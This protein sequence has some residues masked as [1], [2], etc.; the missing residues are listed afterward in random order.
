[1]PLLPVSSG[2][3]PRP[4]PEQGSVPE[5]SHPAIPARPAKISTVMASACSKIPSTFV[6]ARSANPRAIERNMS[7]QRTG[8]RCDAEPTPTGTKPRLKS[9]MG[10]KLTLARAKVSWFGSQSI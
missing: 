8:N 1:M 3:D 4:K 6:S 9:A 10:G 5:S 2:H 7:V